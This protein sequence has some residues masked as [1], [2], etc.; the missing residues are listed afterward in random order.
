MKKKALLSFST[1]TNNDF[2]TVTFSI[3]ES[4]SHLFLKFH[5]TLKFGLCHG[6]RQ[7]QANV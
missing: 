6:Q 1:N 3:N 2:I 4:N 5:F 7:S